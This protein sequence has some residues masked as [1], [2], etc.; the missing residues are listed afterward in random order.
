MLYKPHITWFDCKTVVRDG[1][2]SY[3][4]VVDHWCQLPGGCNIGVTEDGVMVFRRLWC[5]DFDGLGCA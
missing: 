4:P 2:T 5:R 3:Y 1:I